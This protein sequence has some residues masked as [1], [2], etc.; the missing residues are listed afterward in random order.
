MNKKIN[1]NAVYL[2]SENVVAREIEGEL[3]LVPITSGVGD[4]EDELYTLNDTGKII[5]I[6]LGERKPLSSLVTFLSETYDAPLADI[7][8]D[9]KGLLFELL[10]RN[11]VVK[12]DLA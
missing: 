5:W 12:V 11:M 3:I 10:K 8:E 6:R 2:P 7:E 9:V 4:M 1:L